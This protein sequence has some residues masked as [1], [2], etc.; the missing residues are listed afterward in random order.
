MPSLRHS[1]VAVA[2]QFTHSRASK[3]RD[4]DKQSVRKWQNSSEGGG[5]EVLHFEEMLLAACLMQD[6]AGE[7]QTEKAQER[8]QEQ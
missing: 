1:G 6:W 3:E 4:G 5:H 8:C 7:G 2:P